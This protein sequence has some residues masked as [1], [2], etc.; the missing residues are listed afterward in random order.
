MTVTPHPHRSVFK[1]RLATALLAL[2]LLAAG[3]A[4]VAA[5]PLI[6]PNAETGG[7]GGGS[8]LVPCVPASPERTPIPSDRPHP[9]P[10]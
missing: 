4:T 8:V 2:T 6:V 9:L 7:S 5:M 10:E 1:T 3:S